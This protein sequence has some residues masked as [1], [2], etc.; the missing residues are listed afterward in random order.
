MT[1]PNTPDTTLR[2]QLYTQFQNHG[3]PI[4]FL[5]NPKHWQY[6]NDSL[7]EAMKLFDRYSQEIARE[8]RL[9]EWQ[10]FE[11]KSD[12]EDEYTQEYIADRIAEL[13]QKP[14]VAQKV[15]T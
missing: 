15:N 4:G 11:G 6:F 10:I 9:D 5:S 1:K 8:A 13:T 12:I 7:D 2:E 3:L 14:P